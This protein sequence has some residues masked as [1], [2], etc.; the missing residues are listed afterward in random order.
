MKLFLPQRI[1]DFDWYSCLTYAILVAANDEHDVRDV[2]A[3]HI[4]KKEQGI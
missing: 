4:R 1:G 3:T 2:I